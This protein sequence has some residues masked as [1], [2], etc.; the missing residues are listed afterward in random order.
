MAKSV[1]TA[2]IRGS[3]SEGITPNYGR[4]VVLCFPARWCNRRV[5]TTA[6]QDDDASHQLVPP[7]H[8]EI[9]AELL[10]L[11]KREGVTN[12]K[13]T[14]AGR[15]LMRLPISQDEWRRTKPNGID[16][17]RATVRALTCVV[18]SY[19]ATF[20]S[21]DKSGK[22][23]TKKDVRWVILR[24][25]LNLDQAIG[26]DLG[27]RQDAAKLLIGV[28][29][30]MYKDRAAAVYTLFID[31]IV[32]LRESLCRP[33]D[34]WVSE[35]YEEFVHSPDSVRRVRFRSLVLELGEVAYRDL[36]ATWQVLSRT[37]PNL[38]SAIDRY[39]LF[40]RAPEPGAIIF[41]SLRAVGESFYNDFARQYL[42]ELDPKALLLPWHVLSL[43]VLTK[44]AAV[45]DDYDDAAR[46]SDVAI[47]RVEWPLPVYFRD[48]IV[49]QSGGPLFDHVL[50]EPTDRFYQAL[51]ASLELFTQ[52]VMGMDGEGGWSAPRSTLKRGIAA[53]TH[54]EW[55][56]KGTSA[57]D[58]RGLTIEPIEWVDPSRASEAP[59]PTDSETTLRPPDSP[60]W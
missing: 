17:P 23:I 44:D 11:R 21:K 7:T 52:L 48:R 60:E 22:N 41:A 25:E 10:D 32:G 31:Q 38:A 4:E 58:V 47:L 59:Q 8:E 39:K 42:T 43:L 34:E 35:A 19:D 50:N 27:Q 29:D 57:F 14:A 16:L 28:G 3:I 40:S 56:W 6:T 1:G 51:R 26:F 49:R 33:R 15:A 2:S 13:V 24:H 46:E 9:E 18:D 5:T 54:L 12:K 36:A 30:Q 45:Q 53:I 37:T 20:T 55:S